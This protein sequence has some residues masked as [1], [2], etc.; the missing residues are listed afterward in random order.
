MNFY[1]IIQNILET[2]KRHK[3]VNEVSEGDIYVYLNSGEHK[4][5]CVFLTVGEVTDSEMTRNVNCTLFYV[6]RLSSDQSNR[7]TVQSLGITTLGDILDTIEG[8]VVSVN[9]TTFTEKFADMCAGVFA[10]VD[11]TYPLDEVCD[12]HFEVRRLEIT[13]NGIYDTIGYDEFVIEVVDEELVERVEELQQEVEELTANIEQKEQEVEELTANIEQKQQEVEELTANIEQKEQEVEN[14]NT[15]IEQKDVEIAEK[16]VEISDLNTQ[17]STV[18]SISITENGT[19]TPEEGVLGWNVVEVNVEGGG[20][21][22]VPPLVETDEYF[23]IQAIDDDTTLCFTRPTDIEQRGSSNYYIRA[24]RSKLEYSYNNLDNWTA[25]ADLVTFVLNQNERLYIR[26]IDGSWQVS[27]STSNN[28][29]LFGSTKD[30]NVGGDASKLLNSYYLSSTTPT[31]NYANLFRIYGSLLNPGDSVFNIKNINIKTPYAGANMSYMVTGTS[32]IKES[33]TS[34]NISDASNVTNA[35]YMCAY[36]DNLS[37]F[38]VKNLNK[39]TNA[40]NMFI[41]CSSLKTIDA[42]S[43]TGFNMSNVTNTTAMF[44]GCTSLTTAYVNFSKT[45]STDSI[46]AFNSCTSLQGL[47]FEGSINYNLDLTACSLLTPESV[48]SILTAASKTTRST[49][50]KTLKFN[51]SVIKDD[52]MTDLISLCTSKGWT[53]S[54]LNLIEIVDY[55]EQNGF[56]LQS[57]SNDNVISFNKNVLG[58]DLDLT[59]KEISTNTGD[60]VDIGYIKI[61]NTNLEVSLKY[62]QFLD[63]KGYYS[64]DYWIDKE[65][66]VLTRAV[67]TSSKPCIMGGKV[68]NLLLYNIILPDNYSNLFYNFDNLYYCTTINCEKMKSTDYWFASCNNLRGVDKIINTDDVTNFRFMFSECYK[69]KTIGQI[70]VSSGTNFSFMFSNCDLENIT[71]VGSINYNIDFNSCD[72]LTYDSVK[73]ILTACSNTTNTNSKTLKFSRTLTDQ[74]GELTALVAT[75]NTKGWTISGLT[76][77]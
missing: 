56:Y 61:R 17:I 11:I 53:I 26:C 24:N 47:Y 62:N 46:P 5:P 1:N 67:L 42:T 69:L 30:V 74:N 34:F 50:A 55:S 40:S 44:S 28:T 3:N 16:N 4:Y 75:C 14:L 15:T 57:L 41:G 27:A 64:G 71:F 35:S 12:E 32:K 73:S 7:T 18:T 52:T 23:Y 31:I 36:N 8:D 13:E 6:D 2:S 38:G 21:P 19:Y 20:G 54:G 43:S 33:L 72:L 68:K 63:F 29:G 9:Y 48:I 39:V 25:M 58:G 10:T 77:N 45:T 60:F 70:D 51:L 59:F 22:I 37:N 49:V 65:G 76:L 66:S